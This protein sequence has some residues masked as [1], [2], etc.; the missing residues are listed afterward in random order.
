MPH[1]ATPAEL[2]PILA[3]FVNAR[4]QPAQHGPDGWP[5]KRDAVDIHYAGARRINADIRDITAE[6][7]TS[8]FYSGCELIRWED[9]SRIVVRGE[10]CSVAFEVAGPVRRAA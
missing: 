6:G 5:I 4:L 8:F 9:I 3:P 7:I 1:I 2:A 10:G